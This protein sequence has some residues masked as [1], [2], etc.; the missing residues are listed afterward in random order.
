M[1]LI[2]SLLHA[3]A[4]HSPSSQVFR[5]GITDEFACN[6]IIAAR[7]GTLRHEFA[8]GLELIPSKAD[9]QE[10]DRPPNEGPAKF[11]PL[12]LRAAVAPLPARSKARFLYTLRS[13][14]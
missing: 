6:V 5:G 7:P 1:A 4:P 12:M 10:L 3:L 14:A 11:K 8:S 2:V 9:S 13:I